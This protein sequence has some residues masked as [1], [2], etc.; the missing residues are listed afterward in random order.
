MNF[1]AFKPIVFFVL[2]GLMLVIAACG[3][4]AATPTAQPASPTEAPAKPTEPPAATAAPVEPTA[5]PQ[6]Q[7]PASGAIG[8]IGDAQDAIIQIE[9][10]GSFI[11]PQVGQIFNGAGRGSGFIFDPSGLAVTNNHVVTGSAL[12]K[13][14]VGGDQS[15]TLNARVLGVSECSDLAVIDIEG[16]GYPYLD[17]YNGPITVGKEIYVAGFPLGDPEYSLTKGIISKA[18]AD[19]ETSWASVDSVISYDATTNP[20]NSG[21]P[22]LT[23]DAQVVGIHYAGNGDTRQAFGISETIAKTVVDKLKNGE[24]LDWIGVNGSAVANEDGSLTGI[25]VSSVQS[26]SPA[27]KAGLKGGDIITKVENLVMAT[28]GT[29][30]DYCDILRSHKS[31]DTLNLEVLRF[32]TGELLE[33]QLN[34][35]DL[36]VTAV[37][38]NGSSAASDNGNANDTANDNSAQT[39]GSPSGVLNLNASA[40]GE[41]YYET[42]FD[43]PLSDWVYFLMNGQESGFDANIENS[44]L[45]MDISDSNTWVYFYLDS[46][47]VDNVLVETKFEN[48]GRNNNNVS[49]ICRYSDAG[50]YE[51]NVANN[52]EYT[53]FRYDA[54][55]D[56]YTALF[57][58]GSTLIKTGKDSNVITAVCNGD[59]LTLGING[60]AV[61]TIRDKNMKSGK[62]G[63]SLSSFDVTPIVGEFDY[64]VAQVP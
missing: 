24:N 50:W 5:A 53:I 58:G 36:A 12:L 37:L 63:F 52:G 62:V 18:K 27:D 31:S 1:R 43:N 33:G 14:W 59:Q 23:E 39:G 55:E 9:S 2:I 44:T 10:V 6:A 42:D 57:S 48:L 11:D 22:V 51:F 41:S 16:D 4:G 21:G 35:R 40:S 32:G 46:L 60:Q 17:W 34:G 7:E 54:P 45:H 47:D 15:K 28:D 19:G 25:W 13:V 30:A 3:G 8:K 38:D 64:F 49:V 26:G 29:M 20:G 56:K 61:R